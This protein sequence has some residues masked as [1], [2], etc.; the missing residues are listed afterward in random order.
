MKNEL[1]GIDFDDVIFNLSDHL[2]DYF[3]ERF[4]TAFKR[5]DINQYQMGVLWNL[6]KE[7]EHKVIMDFCFSELH[8]GVLPVKGAIEGINELSKNHTLVVV[9]AREEARREMTHAWIDKHLP[10]VFKSV[11]LTH[12]NH[13]DV[14]MRKKKSDICR[15]FGIKVFVDDSLSNVTDVSQVVDTVFL[16]DTPWNQG[17]LPKNVQRVFSWQEIVDKI[18]DKA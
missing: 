8:H 6:S 18:K 15:E 16:L 12:H 11:I 14:S 9:T 2:L 17:E 5:G 10:N 1:I 3:N 13:E 7:E 4:H